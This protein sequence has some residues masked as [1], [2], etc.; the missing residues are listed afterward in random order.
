MKWWCFNEEQLRE[1]LESY[2]SAHAAEQR[3]NVEIDGV[4]VRGDRG[5]I[6]DVLVRDFLNSEAV[7]GRKMRRDNGGSVV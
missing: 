5:A 2:R 1:A 3:M 7:R 6:A 4:E